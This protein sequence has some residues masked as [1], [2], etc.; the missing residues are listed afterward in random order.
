MAAP[1]SSLRFWRCHACEPALCSGKSALTSNNSS[2][3]GGTMAHVN[4]IISQAEVRC[5]GNRKRTS[6][7]LTACSQP[8]DVEASNYRTT[9]HSVAGLAR[10]QLQMDV[11]TAHRATSF[12]NMSAL[13]LNSYASL[14]LCIC[15]GEGTAW[16]FF[17]CC[18]TGFSDCSFLNRKFGIPQQQHSSCTGLP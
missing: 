12:R 13:F 17:L 14:W 3:R 7:P 18:S 11:M 10:G 6:N 2:H 5:R 15:A 4:R 1:F 9:H 8:G 16:I